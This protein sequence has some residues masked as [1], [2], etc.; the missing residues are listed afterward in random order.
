[1]ASFVNMSGTP[2]KTP[3]FDHLN[4]HLAEP[5]NNVYNFG[6]VPLEMITGRV[7]YSLYDGSV[8]V[9]AYDFLRSKLSLGEL[10]DPTLKS[11]QEDKLEEIGEVTKS[12]MELGPK[13]RPAMRKVTVRLRERTAIGP[14]GAIPRLSPLWWA[15]LEILSDTKVRVNKR[16]KLKW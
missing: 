1:M 9:W 4:A 8:E 12:C 6:L 13:Q 10:L 7:P 16:D 14:D 15:E 5:E 2:N 3:G 11:F